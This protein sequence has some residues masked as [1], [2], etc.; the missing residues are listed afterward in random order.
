MRVVFLSLALVAA[1]ACGGADES[2]LGGPYGGTGSTTN[3]TTGNTSSSGDDAA[4]TGTGDDSTGGGDD[5]GG[6]GGGGGGGA[7]SGGGG[8]GGGGAIDASTGNV[9]S[10]GGGGS[11]DA[12]A[13]PPSAPTWSQLF[14]NYLASG[15]EG[16]CRGCHSQGSSASS[17]Y[18]WLNGRG[19]MTAPN[20]TLLS[21]ARDGLTWYGGGMPTNGAPSNAQAVTDFNAWAAAG[22]Q[23]N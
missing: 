4:S 2:P 9:D 17:L 16:D 23:D 3:P 22:A 1:A 14:T 12:S 18:S 15:T 8:G 20:P 19:Y 6:G 21:S 13:P 7:D 11:P 5:S 10:G